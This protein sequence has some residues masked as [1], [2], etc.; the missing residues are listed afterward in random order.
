MAIPLLASSVRAAAPEIAVTQDKLTELTDG[1]S[2]VTFTSAKIGSA[3]T[4]KTLTIHNVGTATLTKLSVYVDGDAPFDYIVPIL[5]VATLAPNTFYTFIVTFNPTVVG[6]RNAALHI[7]SNDANENPFD[8][9]LTATGLQPDVIAP[10]IAVSKYNDSVELVDGIASLAY[11]PVKLGSVGGTET[12]SIRNLGNADLSG[13]ALSL[14]GNNASDFMLS[15]LGTTTVS[16]GGILNF[17]ITF[18][19]TAV[20]TR[21][22]VLHIASNDSDENPFDIKLTG[23]AEAPG[24]EIEVYKANNTVNL[25]DGKGDVGFGS[26]RIGST[27]VDRTLTIRN[28]GN[29]DLSGLVLTVDGDGASDFTAATLDATTVSP[30]AILNFKVTFN[31]TALGSRTATLHIA[32]N[33]AD[34]NPFDILLVGTGLEREVIAPEIAV[35]KANNA[36]NLTDGDAKL[37]FDPVKLGSAGATKT[38]TIHNLGNG[39]LSGLAL[40]VDG[41]NAAD[42]TVSA[43][44]AKSVLPGAILKFTVTFKPKAVGA[45]NAALHI[46][47]ND[48]DENPFDIRLAGSGAAAEGTAPEIAVFKAGSSL[49]LIDGSSQ[50]GF[51]SVKI[52]TAGVT[53]TLFIYNFGDAVLSNLALKLDGVNAGDFT[54]S[55]LAASSISPGSS[56]MF[57]VRFKPGVVGTRTA[58]LHIASNDADENPF[59][60]KLVGSGAASA[61]VVSPAVQ[62]PVAAVVSTMVI[63]GRKYHCITIQKTL[64]FNPKPGDVEVSGDLVHWSSGAQYTTV[65]RNDA[66]V[67]QVRDNTPFTRDSKRY[68][69]L[70]PKR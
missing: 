57:T 30:G 60:I 52:G 5:G 45:R 58:A 66:S 23:I 62:E 20:G 42:F 33:D 2:T 46:A 26:A 36:I 17:K 19:P 3:G 28:L 8:I 34:E 70:H 64:G 38:L 56:Q 31:P 63:E 39:V 25:L 4:T 10:E 55:A 37:S 21:T 16:P 12:L 41:V 27:G 11:D 6:V 48:A 9:K 68:I 14:D 18:K 22:A 13:L 29:A 7:T 50:L 35:Y 67:L 54:V 53:K 32:S 51:D 15:K 24:P 47:S 1:M 65:V 69:R 44:E 59:D 43:L 61:S 40:K 49:G